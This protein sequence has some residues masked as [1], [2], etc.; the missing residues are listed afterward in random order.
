MHSSALTQDEIEELTSW[1][2]FTPRE[3][4]VLFDRFSE[5]DIRSQGYLTFI[6]LMRIPELHSNPLSNL[7]IREIEHIID[8]NNISFPH[9]LE[10]MEIFSVRKDKKFR[11]S[12]LFRVFDL[13][14]DNKLCVHTL[15]KIGSLID[16]N[17]FASVLKIYDIDNKGYLSY[18]DFTRFYITQHLDEAMAIDFSRN[19]PEKKTMNLIDETPDK[20]IDLNTAAYLLNV[21]KRRIYDITNVLEGLNLLQKSHVNNVRWTGEDIKTYYSLDAEDFDAS[22]SEGLNSDVSCDMGNDAIAPDRHIETEILAADRTLDILYEEIS[23]LSQS[24]RNTKNAYVTY[25]DLQSLDALDNKLVFAVKTPEN[26]KIEFADNE[27]LPAAEH[28]EDPAAMKEYIENFASISQNH[29]DTSDYDRFYDHCKVFIQSSSVDADKTY[30]SIYSALTVFSNKHLISIAFKLLSLVNSS[31]EVEASVVLKYLSNREVSSSVFQYL[32]TIRDRAPFKQAIIEHLYDPEYESASFFDLVS[33]PEYEHDLLCFLRLEAP[34]YLPKK[35]KTMI[36][37]RRFCDIGRYIVHFGHRDS[38]I[39]F[40]VYELFVLY[41]QEMG[42][43]DCHIENVEV[44]V[45][46]EDTFMSFKSKIHVESPSNFLFYFF[47]FMKERKALLER[48]RDDDVRGVEEV[49]SKYL[50]STHKFKISTRMRSLREYNGGGRPLLQHDSVSASLKESFDYLF[51]GTC[52][53]NICDCI[54]I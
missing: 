37:T 27:A 24:S 50:A 54:E 48:I 23:K 29:V 51:G 21:G 1:T 25:N 32:L 46:G 36:N 5:L 47:D 17:D 31:K 8:Y 18:K 26:I 20:I 33:L 12:F 41:F 28:A 14:N 34:G 43:A 6:E 3:I 16:N 52:Y 4:E 39:C 11:I 10:I 35:L 45:C 44:A 42:A 22:C 49:L 7:I 53:K 15:M 2:T 19:I 9:F 40:L 13:N 30:D 38:Y